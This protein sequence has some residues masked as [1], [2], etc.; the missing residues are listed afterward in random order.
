MH[1]NTIFVEKPATGAPSW[2]LLNYNGT[3]ASPSNPLDTTGADLLVAA[4]AGL[5]G[6]S[7]VTDN[8]GN[9]WIAGAPATSGDSGI[10]YCH[11]GIVGPGH[12]VSFTTNYPS[13]VFAAYSGSA[14][15]PLDQSST[16][17][18]AQPGPVTPS[19]NGELILASLATVGGDATNAID[20]GFSIITNVPTVS[21]V[22]MGNTLA[23]LIQGTAATVNPTWTTSGAV[24]G[25]AIASFK[26]HP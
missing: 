19:Q 10:Y 18:G 3:G 8:L 20:S 5:G 26:L 1:R 12:T 16:S 25:S 13:I 14:A 7:G 22:S 17:S 6:I 24:Y 2:K 11:G 23:S 4:I 21:G 9:T 15:S